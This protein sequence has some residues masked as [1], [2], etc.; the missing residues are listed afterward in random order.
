MKHSCTL[1]V[2]EDDENDRLLLSHA[3][4]KARY[5]GRL[6]LVNDGSEAI[7]YLDGAGPYADRDKYPFPQFIIIDLKMPK[8]DGYAILQHI[9][10]NPQWAIIPVVVLTASADP[11]DVKKAY[12]LG[13][14]C[15]HV[16]PNSSEGLVRQV[17]LLLEYW[18]TCQVPLVDPYGKLLPTHG[19]GK[20][21]EAIRPQV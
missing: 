8:A 7:A 9:R 11:D 5:E 12:L 13:A 18:E 2:A 4:K 17:R 19:T 15:Y 10:R 16:K 14:S 3:L 21:G 1:L 6:T 20:L